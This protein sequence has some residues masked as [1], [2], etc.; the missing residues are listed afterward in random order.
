MRT[1]TPLALCAAALASTLLLAGCGQERFA[2]SG[3]PAA[4]GSSAGSG[5][6]SCAPAVPGGDP[7]DLKRDDV[8][9]IVPDCAPVPVSGTDFQV[10]NTREETLTYTI[11]FDLLDASG[12]VMDNTEETVGSVAPGRTVKG[13]VHLDNSTPGANPG[14]R[15]GIAR[16]RAVPADEAPSTAGACPPSGVRIAADQGDA[17]M[18]LRVVGIDLTNCGSGDYTVDGYPGLQLLDTSLKPVTGVRVLDGTDQISTGIGGDGPPRP[19]TLRPGE[20][21]H[22]TLAWRNT[23]EAG[24]P[25]NVPYVRVTAKPGAPTVIVTPELDLGTTGRLGVGPWRAARSSSR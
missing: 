21:A 20:S 18:G 3:S 4:S 13:S 8:T 5:S 19:V 2:D 25:V 14:A 17:A 24:D 9:V 22:A 15:V 12:G 7:A 11:L 6:S 1:A 10:T 23:T 16:V